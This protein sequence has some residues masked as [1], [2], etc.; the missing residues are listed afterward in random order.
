MLFSVDFLIL[1]LTIHYFLGIKRFLK[2]L[3]VYS[4][5]NMENHT[6]I[7]FLIF[8]MVFQSTY[9]KKDI[10]SYTINIFISIQ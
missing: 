9:N 4:I 5:L 6:K 10:N 7:F 1:F 8:S 3:Y 2:K